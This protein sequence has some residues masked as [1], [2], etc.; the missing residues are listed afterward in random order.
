MIARLAGLFTICMLTTGAAMA[1]DVEVTPAREL[2]AASLAHDGDVQ[3]DWGLAEAWGWLGGAKLIQGDSNKA[4]P[5]FQR[6]LELTKDF[7]W[8]SRVAMVQAQRPALT[9][10]GN[11]QTRPRSSVVRV[12]MSFVVAEWL[13]AIWA[14]LRNIVE[15][16][17]AWSR[18]LFRQKVAGGADALY[19]SIRS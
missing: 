18:F 5:A 8:V 13:E 17:N 6:A 11:D 2:Q 9:T 4:V 12:R 7:W 3:G 14:A 15:R 10:A 19:P 16:G 1:P